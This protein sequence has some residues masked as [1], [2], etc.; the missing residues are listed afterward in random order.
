MGHIV[1]ALAKASQSF[2]EH[3]YVH[4]AAAGYRFVKYLVVRNSASATTLPAQ[5]GTN[6]YLS[7]ARNGDTAEFIYPL[8]KAC[9][10]LC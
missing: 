6:H 1:T 9:S 7:P 3:G 4:V 2:V 10:V 5:N 8:P